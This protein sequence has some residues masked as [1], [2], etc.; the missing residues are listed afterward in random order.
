MT[1]L[2][3]RSRFNSICKDWLGTF[4]NLPS[5]PQVPLEISAIILSYVTDYDT[6]CLIK[7]NNILSINIP[8]QSAINKYT[9]T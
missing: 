3:I 6:E 9:I 8:T 1:I 4:C 2:S 7:A 5:M